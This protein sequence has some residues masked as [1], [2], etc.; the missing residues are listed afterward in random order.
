MASCEVAILGSGI[1]ATVAAISCQ[2]QGV[3]FKLIHDPQAVKH[4]PVWISNDYTEEF[5]ETKL[6][7]Q[8]TESVRMLTSRTD[9]SITHE[10]GKYWIINPVRAISTIQERIDPNRI[11][12]VGKEKKSI[13]IEN[14]GSEFNILGLSE[15][16]QC[17]KV[18][19]ATG[20]NGITKEAGNH[21]VE[22]VYGGSFR[23]ALETPEMILIFLEDGG[24]SWIAPSIHKGFIDVVYT[25]WGPKN[26]HKDF[27]KTSAKR[28]ENLVKF[29][30]MSKGIRFY[31]FR[32]EEIYSGMISAQPYNHRVQ[33]RIFPFGEAAQTTRPA[34]QESFNRILATADILGKSIAKNTSSFDYLKKLRDLQRNDLYMYAGLVA[35]ILLHQSNGVSGTTVNGMGRMIEKQPENKKGSMESRIEEWIKSGRVDKQTII[36]IG[37]SDTQLLRSLMSS[38]GAY[39]MAGFIGQNNLLK[40]MQFV[41]EKILHKGYLKN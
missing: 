20:I 28:L 5:P 13:K 23:G 10:P 6:G 37:L 30:F 36:Q 8:P 12:T 22:W 29:A 9:Y 34:S 1:A 18:V 11:I 40:A 31:S 24:T 32:P 2:K 16:I 21:L 27:M 14:V 35:R 7:M 26:R 4:R 15:R 17:G 41:N 3:D 33:N 19:D 38:G 25:A 39:L